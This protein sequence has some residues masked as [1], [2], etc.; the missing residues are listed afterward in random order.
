LLPRIQ[1]PDPLLDTALQCEIVAETARA[2]GTTDPRLW[3]ES[4]LAWADARR[5]YDRTYARLREAEALFA[6][7]ARGPAKEAL[8]EA[9]ASASA[10][11][12]RLMRALADDLARR[13]R[14]SPEPPHRRQADRD[15]PTPRE[16][17]VLR[18]L[19]EGLTNREIAARLFLSPKTVGIHI[20][21]LH[22]KLDAHT[23]GKAVAAARRQGILV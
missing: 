14:V 7:G 12:A 18:L 11:G 3:S 2:K 13:A 8:R 9:A 20:S 17:D 15:E 1:H 6:V 23:R 16:L 4:A 21:R 5:P 22:R 19:A 10:L